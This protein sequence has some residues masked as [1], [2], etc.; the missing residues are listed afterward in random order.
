MPL[1]VTLGELRRL[2]P[3]ERERCNIAYKWVVESPFLYTWH[4]EG[5]GHYHVSVPIG[6]LM[7][8]ASGCAPDLGSSWVF[9][10][11]LYATHAFTSGQPCSRR[12]AD[13]V[14]HRVLRHERLPF[15]AWTF[16]HAARLNPLWGFS[17]AWKK[18]GNR[19]PQ[20]LAPEA[21][22]VLI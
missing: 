21:L 18:S 11:W 14:M 16:R 1:T 4:E 3:Q 5:V 8:G 10:D 9:H 2:T 6:F 12:E 17:R 13:R 7:D 20:C 22:A 15:F 19:G